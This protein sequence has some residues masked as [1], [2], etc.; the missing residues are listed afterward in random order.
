MFA[1]VLMIVGVLGRLGSDRSSIMQCQIRSICS[2]NNFCD[3]KQTL[4][5]S[6]EEKWYNKLPVH[7][8]S[9]LPF[10]P[11]ILLLLLLLAAL[12]MSMDRMR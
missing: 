10:Y 8:H 9:H 5:R 1:M 11:S 12:V 2:P 7:G 4:R 3:F 6:G